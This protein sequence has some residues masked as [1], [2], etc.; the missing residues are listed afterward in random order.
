[1]TTLEKLQQHLQRP[2]FSLSDGSVCKHLATPLEC[3]DGS[4][5]YIQASRLHYCIPNNDIGPYTHVEVGSGLEGAAWAE[6][7]YVCEDEDET[8]ANVPIEMVVEEID[9]RGGFKVK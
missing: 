7:Y 5:M 9:R 4:I 1:M 2:Y 8:Y 6:P 3:A